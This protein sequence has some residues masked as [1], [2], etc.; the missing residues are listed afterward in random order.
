MKTKSLLFAALVFVTS[1]AFAGKDE[2]R[3]T[4]M[5]IVPVKGSETFKVIYKGAT[6]GKVKLNIYNANGKVI[7]TE[8]FA[9]TD[10]FIVP[11]NFSGLQAGEYTIELIDATGKKSEKVTLNTEKKS[12][13]V[14]HISKIGTE[15]GKFLLSVANTK[16]G[17]KINVKIY[18]AKNNLIHN[19]TQSVNADFA[20]VYKLNTVSEAFTFEVTDSTGKTKTIRF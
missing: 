8:S 18:D 12:A 2:P 4:G 1:I 6:A 10:G 11:I 13:G 7:L 15:N 5:A 19:E 14:V 3:R 16:P 9:G 17:S 20:Q